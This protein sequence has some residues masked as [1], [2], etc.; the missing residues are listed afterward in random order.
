MPAGFFPRKRGLRQGDSLSLFLFVLIMERLS[1][2]IKKVSQLDW[3]KGFHAEIR[4]QGTIMISHLLD[5]NDT[6]IMC[7]ASEEQILYL[8]TI[9]LLFEAISGLHIKYAKSQ[10]LVNKV[11]NIQKLAIFN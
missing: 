1:R 9:L 11:S 10:I 7:N 6:L 3:I 8:K 2:K 5:T 4:G